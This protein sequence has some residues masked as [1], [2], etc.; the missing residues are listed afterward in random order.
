MRAA[1][2]K[3]LRSFNVRYIGIYYIDMQMMSFGLVF[4]GLLWLLVYFL[5]RKLTFLSKQLTNYKDT[6]SYRIFISL[7]IE[8]IYNIS[9]VQ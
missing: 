3:L 8:D 6:M 2:V 5:L 7:A 9:V 4:T 1:R